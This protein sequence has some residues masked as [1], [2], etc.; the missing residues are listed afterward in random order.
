MGRLALLLVFV[1]GQALAFNLATDSKGN[2]VRWRGQVEF[3]LDQNFAEKLRLPPS[4]L[5]A[6]E[7]A[8]KAYDAATAALKVTVRRGEP[9]AL[10]YAQEPGATNQSVIIVADEWAFSPAAVATTLVTVRVSTSEIIDADI[11]FNA[12]GY[13]FDVVGDTGHGPARNARS[14]DVQN[15]VMHELGHALGLAHNPDD[16][17]A[18]MFPGAQPQETKKRK[19]S[20]DDEAGLAE[21]YAVDAFSH[22]ELLTGCSSAPGGSGAWLALALGLWALLRLKQP[23]LAVAARRVTPVVAVLLSAQAGTAS[24]GKPGQG[25]RTPPDEVAWAEV[26]D[27]RARWLPG[28]RVIVTDVEVE[29]R[30]CVRGDCPKGRLVVQVLGGRVGDIEQVVAHQPPVVRGT[31]LLLEKKGTRR[32]VVPTTLSAATPALAT[33]R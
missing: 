27:T 4:A 14:Y 33:T 20:P 3:V 28:S 19:L 13:D 5:E 17:T 22:P 26:V 32:V 30:T 21:L 31:R 9:V 2:V 8:V 12:D 15:T 1:S 6:V 16:G 11:V 18:V 24:A 10:G 23:R 29:V 25:A 7:K